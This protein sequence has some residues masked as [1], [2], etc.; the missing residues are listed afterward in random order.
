M[1]ERWWRLIIAGV[2]ML[3]VSLVTIHW[4]NSSQIFRA[5]EENTHVVVFTLLATFGAIKLI[6]AD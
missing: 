1:S 3:S 6:N 4:A 2:L 5:I